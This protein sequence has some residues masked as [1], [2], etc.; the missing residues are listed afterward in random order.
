[1]ANLKVS[2]IVRP[3]TGTRTPVLANGKMDPEGTYYLR[4]C[5]GKVPKLIR[6]GSNFPDQV[7]DE[8]AQFRIQEDHAFILRR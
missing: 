5:V 8:M 6:V 7:M 2:I 3:T 1:M 4:C